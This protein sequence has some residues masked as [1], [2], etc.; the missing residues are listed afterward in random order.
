MNNS[1]KWDSGFGGLHHRRRNRSAGVFP[2]LKDALPFWMRLPLLPLRTTEDQGEE[3]DRR[4][5]GAQVGPA[6]GGRAF[7]TK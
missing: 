4:A 3:G 7:V 5:W 1:P 6:A 2:F